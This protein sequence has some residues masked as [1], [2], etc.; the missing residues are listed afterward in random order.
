MHGRLHVAF[1]RFIRVPIFDHQHIITLMGETDLT[2]V[3]NSGFTLAQSTI[4]LEPYRTTL[5][6][7]RQQRPILPC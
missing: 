5:L 3:Y 2:W 1:Q 6:R 7:L 4:L